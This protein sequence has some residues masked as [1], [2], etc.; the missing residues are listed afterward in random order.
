[1]SIAV[2]GSLLLQTAQ[3]ATPFVDLACHP[4]VGTTVA[5]NHPLLFLSEGGERGVTAMLTLPAFGLDFL[6]RT[7]D[8]FIYAML[9][10]TEM[11]KSKNFRGEGA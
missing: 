8:V 3:S 10:P 7:S 4:S 9:G 1:M 11:L 5:R 6:L 2:A